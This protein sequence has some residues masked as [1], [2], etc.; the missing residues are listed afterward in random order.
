MEDGHDGAELEDA[1]LAREED[2]GAD[3]ISGRLASTA[4]SP[5]TLSSSPRRARGGPLRLPVA[6]L[7]R[8]LPRDPLLFPTP[9]R[10]G[11][12]AAPRRAASP[13]PARARAPA[14]P[15]PPAR[16]RDESERGAAPAVCVARGGRRNFASP[17]SS[18]A[19]CVL[20]IGHR[21]E[22]D[23]GTQNTVWDAN[24]RLGRGVGD[25]LSLYH[26]QPKCSTRI[27]GH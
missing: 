15:P 3:A 27:T 17:L 7:L 10:R 11:P 14:P 22:A 2:D 20:R 23:S 5:V 12:T 26:Y 13:P 9:R 18:N 21:L 25:S 1:A 24:M 16:G 6:Q 8:L 4:S 19:N